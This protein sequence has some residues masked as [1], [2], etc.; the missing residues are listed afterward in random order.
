VSI[1]AAIVTSTRPSTNQSVADQDYFRQ[2]RDR[3]SFF[4]GKLPRAKTGEAKL[5]FI[6]RLE[7]N[8]VFDG[9]II[10]AVDAAYFVSGYEASNLGEHGVIGILGTDGVFR[11]GRT[12]ESV[13]TG[14]SLSIRLRGVGA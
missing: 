4:I 13:L 3:N 2:Q 7:V 1:I 12:G 11:V 8:R 6:R 5:H 10:L 14:G 9:V